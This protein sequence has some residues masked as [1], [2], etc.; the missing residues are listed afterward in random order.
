MS[1]GRKNNKDNLNKVIGISI[2]SAFAFVVALVCNIIPPVAGFLS[3][4]AKDAVISVAA[5]V[6][7]PISG[8]IIS[9]V[10]A[11]LEFLTFSTTGWYGLVMNF[12]S[13]AV[14][15][16]TAA[17]IYKFRRNIN[18]ALI[19][20]LSAII[21]TAGLMLLLNRFV[22]PVYLFEYL[23]IMPKEAA[24]EYVIGII[25]TILLPFNLAKSMLN[26]AVA[27]LLYKPIVTALR[28]AKIA[29]GSQNAVKFNRSSVIILIVGAVV[30]A[31]SITILL[32]IW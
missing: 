20:Y 12:A 25:P 1:A 16:L 6:Y 11:L 22:T 9:L 32:L 18:G 13:S 15:S 31:A 26:A 17:L 8:V 10:A 29:S 19:G 7:G 14:F 3:L 28:K 2:F 23:G 4:D 24:T 21:T 5:F 30:L 27:M